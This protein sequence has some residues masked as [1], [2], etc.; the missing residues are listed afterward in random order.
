MAPLRL[1]LTRLPSIA[2]TPNPETK[3]PECRASAATEGVSEHPLPVAT[4][5]LY[6][7]FQKKQ[8]VVN[9]FRGIERPG[10]P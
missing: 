1:L 5:V 10:Y 3:I 7:F 6:G 4:A 2:Q 8:P 9:G